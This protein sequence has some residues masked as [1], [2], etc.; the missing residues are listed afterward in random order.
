MR[1]FRCALQD[2]REGQKAEKALGQARVYRSPWGVISPASER[3]EGVSESGGVLCRMDE[4]D[5]ERRKLWDR[6]EGAA[7]FDKRDRK[8]RKRWD[9]CQCAA[10]LG[11]AFCVLSKAFAK[12]TSADGSTHMKLC[13][14]IQAR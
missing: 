10:V 14:R 9:R 2:G 1:R 12:G 5:R 6:H 3:C 11:N 4:R 7:A 8:R 13:F